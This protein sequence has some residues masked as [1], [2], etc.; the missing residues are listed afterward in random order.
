[1]PAV[2]APSAA[3]VWRRLTGTE[4]A[5]ALGTT[6]YVNGRTAGTAMGDFDMDAAS[7]I[8]TVKLPVPADAAT[9]FMRTIGLKFDVTGTTDWKLL[10]GN[11]YYERERQPE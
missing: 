10:M 4:S 1:M 7:G 11:L 2:P 5:D 8:N 3:S 9:Q 6:Y